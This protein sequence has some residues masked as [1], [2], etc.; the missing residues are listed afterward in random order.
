MPLDTNRGS[1]R[2][3]G[4]SLERLIMFLMFG[5]RPGFSAVFDQP[6]RRDRCDSGTGNDTAA[7]TPLPPVRHPCTAGQRRTASTARGASEN[8]I[9]C[10]APSIATAQRR[11]IEQGG[12]LKHCCDPRNRAEAEPNRFGLSVI[13]TACCT[14]QLSLYPPALPRHTPAIKGDVSAIPG[15]IARNPS[16]VGFVEPSG[17]F[18]LG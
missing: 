16:A 4:A 6:P 10:R 7:G 8:P 14:K 2:P 15:I 17:A 11:I 18:I 3:F 12:C 13:G 1:R 5:L 9:A